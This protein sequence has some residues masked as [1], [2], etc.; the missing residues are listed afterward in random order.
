[1][2]YISLNDR[3]FQYYIFN[4]LL[5]FYNYK[6]NKEIGIDSKNSN[7]Y[8]C[9]INDKKFDFC[10]KKNILPEELIIML[11]LS[12]LVLNNTNPHFLICYKQLNKNNI[13][14]ELATG[15]LKSFLKSYISK[16]VLFNSIIQII[17]SIYSFH[18]Y[19]NRSHNDVHHGNFL[20]HRIDKTDSYFYY[21]IN[22]IEFYLKNEGYLWIINDFDMSSIDDH[23]YDDYKYGMEAFKNYNKNKSKSVK[24]MIDN[25]IDI[26]WNNN[27][28]EVLLLELIKEYN[29]TSYNSIK[30]NKNPI[31]L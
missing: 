26:I 1:M 14:C 2:K 22:D 13:L 10:S 27:I 28:D 21:K 17:I 9:S 20:Y 5:S 7:I 24:Q 16:N 8:I 11:K 25:I 23:K 30:Y 19:T 18:K 29:L 6:I 12:S 15:D 3:I 4:K 31:Q